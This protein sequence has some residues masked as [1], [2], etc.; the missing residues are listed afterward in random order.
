MEMEMEV[1]R[2]RRRIGVGGRSQKAAAAGEIDVGIPSEIGWD[3]TDWAVRSFV[4]A[5]C[6]GPARPMK[7]PRRGRKP[8]VGRVILLLLP[9][10]ARPGYPPLCCASSS[11]PA[12]PL[13]LLRAGAGAKPPLSFSVPPPPGDVRISSR[14]PTT[15]TR[16]SSSSSPKLSSATVQFRS[17]SDP[18]NQPTVDDD[19]DFDLKGRKAIP[20]I[21]VPRQ[22]YIAVSKPALLDAL[23]SLFPSQPPTPSPTSAAAADFKRFARFVAHLLRSSLQVQFNSIQ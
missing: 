11:A 9:A 1:G 19:G 17:D 10:I 3:Q 22:R 8:M 18:W 6:H 7:I 20:G 15:A 2:R 4:V 12:M 14:P 16:C 13:L 5:T 21:H 23:L